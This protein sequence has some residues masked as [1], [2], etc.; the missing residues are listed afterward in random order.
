[1]AGNAAGKEMRVFTDEIK[2]SEYILTGDDHR[3]VAYSLRSKVGDEIVLCPQDGYDYFGKIERIEKDRTTVRIE[4]KERGAGEPETEIAVFCAVPNKSEKSDLIAQKLTELGVGTICP[5]VTD[6]VSV[7]DRAVK[8][9]RLNRICE[10][11]AKQC[12]RSIVPKV[13]EPIPF[14]EAVKRLPAFDL[15]VF[16]YEKERELSLKEFMS[17]ITTKP[18][19]VAIVIGA[20]GGFSESEVRA[21]HDIGVKSVTLGNRILRT[22]TANIAVVAVVAYELGEWTA[23]RGDI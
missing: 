5:T 17:G 4:K 20:E 2:G 12:G 22:E 18:K 19:T 7:K 16:P 21:L 23:K 6:F 11:A 9:E 3:H 13:C 8:T 1:M 10:E 15:A 14:A